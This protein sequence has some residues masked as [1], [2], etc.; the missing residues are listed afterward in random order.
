MASLAWYPAIA[1]AP[2]KAPSFVEITEALTRRA[3][4]PLRPDHVFDATLAPGIDLLDVPDEVKAGLYLLN[5]DLER[6]H[7]LAQAHE[8]DK[9]FDFWHAIVHRREGDFD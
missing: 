5:D 1:G 4:Y 9:T 8:G 3:E 2:M 7:E 6:A